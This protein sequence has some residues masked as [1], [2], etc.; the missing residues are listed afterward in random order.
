MP[1]SHTNISDKKVREERVVVVA[2]DWPSGQY[3]NWV[4]I[5]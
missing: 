5:E 2:A 4:G 3:N 1:V